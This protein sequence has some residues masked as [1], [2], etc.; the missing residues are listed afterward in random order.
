MKS[1][2]QN[3]EHRK[4]PVYSNIKWALDLELLYHWT[5]F[6]PQN[7]KVKLTEMVKRMKYATL[8]IKSGDPK[9]HILQA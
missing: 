9:I 6:G 4:L 5:I 3:I 8:T 1:F 2:P 7:L